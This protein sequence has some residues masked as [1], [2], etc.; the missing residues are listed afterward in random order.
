[1]HEEIRINSVFPILKAAPLLDELTVD[2]ISR[3]KP[4]GRQDMRVGWRKVHGI[5]EIGG[6]K[7]V[8]LL[9]LPPNAIAWR[10]FLDPLGILLDFF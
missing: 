10:V 5:A 3:R 6:G 9:G 8:H 4:L 1:M 7:R 2:L